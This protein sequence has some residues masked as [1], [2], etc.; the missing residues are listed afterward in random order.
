MSER[1]WLELENKGTSKGSPEGAGLLCFGCHRSRRVGYCYWEVD[2]LEVG[3]GLPTGVEVLLAG[4][5]M[6]LLLMVLA[7]ER[8]S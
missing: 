3:L 7:S 5:P 1:F 8:G 2:V 4:W 6:L